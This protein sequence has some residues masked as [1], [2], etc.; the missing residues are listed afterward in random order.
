MVITKHEFSNRKHELAIRPQE[1]CRREPW[2]P[3]RF[4]HAGLVTGEGPDKSSTLVLQVG[5]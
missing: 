5:G 3:G 1:V 2:A 4:N